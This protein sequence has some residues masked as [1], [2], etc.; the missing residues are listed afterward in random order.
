MGGACPCVCVW[1]PPECLLSVVAVD[2]ISPLRYCCCCLAEGN[3]ENGRTAVKDT[4]V[5][6]SAEKTVG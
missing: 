1:L 3:D 4:E 5:G 6:G 2:I